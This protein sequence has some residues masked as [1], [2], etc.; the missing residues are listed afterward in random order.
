MS[1]EIDY[2]TKYLMYKKK[3]LTLK[4]MIE[5]GADVDYVSHDYQKK[6]IDQ[7]IPSLKMSLEILKRAK[8]PGLKVEFPSD[9]EE[10][11]PSEILEWGYYQH[12][13]GS[14]GRT[15]KKKGKKGPKYEMR[16]LKADQFNLC[17]SMIVNYFGDS[18]GGKK[19]TSLKIA[20]RMKV[21]T[22]SELAKI[23]NHN[24]NKEE[25]LNLIK[26]IKED[27]IYKKDW[28]DK[29]PK[30]MLDKLEKLL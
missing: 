15:K 16:P 27:E 11:K 2:Y 13:L 4:S 22:I 29:D 26:Q 17:I 23:L 18:Q 21:K 28:F 8:E 19:S 5:G 6:C 7:I 9:I 1:E 20:E 24:F 25:A 14:T 12:K 30:A 10:I 3:Y